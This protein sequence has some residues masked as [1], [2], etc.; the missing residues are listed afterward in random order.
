MVEALAKS[1]P[2]RREPSPIDTALDTAIITAPSA[3]DPA[4]L[5]KLDA[6][7]RRVFAP[8]S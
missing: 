4:M 8:Q 1:L 7:G 5:A 6:V 3:R 2:A